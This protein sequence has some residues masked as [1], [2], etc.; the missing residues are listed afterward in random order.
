MPR[1]GNNDLET[2]RQLGERYERELREMVEDGEISP[3]LARRIMGDLFEPAAA[4]EPRSLRWFIWNAHVEEADQASLR[5]RLGKFGTRLL[6]R[7]PWR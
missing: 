7:R 6:A 4:G 5:V 1:S 2:P 3:D